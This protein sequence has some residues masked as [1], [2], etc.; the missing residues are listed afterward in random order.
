[1]AGDFPSD[2]NAQLTVTIVIP[3][4]NEEGNIPR[5]EREV[6]KAVD[7]LP[8]RCE[9]IVIDNDST[10]GTGDLVKE[11]CRRDPRW[12]YLKFSRN[13]S[14]EMSI[15]AGYHYASGDAI[16]V[17]Y[18]DLQDPPA[19][20]PRL[21]AKWR[22]GYDVVYA[23]PSVRAGD[24]A[25]R[26]IA[27]RLAYRLIAWAADV[28]IPT[29]AGDFRLITRHVRDALERCNEYNRYSRGL[30]AWL[31]FRQTGITYER[32][33][34]EAGESKAPIWHTFLITV[35]AITSFSLKP[36]RVFTLFGLAMIGVSGLA[37]LA[38]ISLFFIG[39]P[40]PGLT[41]LICLVLFGI[42]LNSAGIG[43]LGEYLGRTYAETKRRPLY[44]VQE[45]F[46]MPQPELRA[47][48]IQDC[49]QYGSGSGYST[50]QTLHE[51][52]ESGR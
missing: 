10:D 6:R 18:S 52:Q 9:F 46:S 35:N 49:I 23:V 37:L 39:S 29:N 13:F 11:I 22:E 45:S 5:L 47:E 4:F 8:Y 33:P 31:G 44:V 28:P 51:P 27:A 7:T 25:W 43:V 2:A 38:Y 30:I 40:L 42:G 21:L 17:L 14:V 34:R 36:L 26:I 15:A 20:I 32:R 50:K 1:V 41:T 16:I 24:P 48:P 12:R 3:A 19:A